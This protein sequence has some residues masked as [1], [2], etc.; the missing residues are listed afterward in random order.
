MKETHELAGIQ[1]EEISVVKSTLIMAGL[2]SFVL[3]RVLI[4][5]GEDVSKGGLNLVSK[6]ILLKENMKK[7]SFLRAI[8]MEISSI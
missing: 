3:M 1:K 2:K 6:T 5:E 7:G 8:T 4:N